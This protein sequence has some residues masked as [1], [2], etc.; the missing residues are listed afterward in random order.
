MDTVEERAKFT[1]RA[2]NIKKWYNNYKSMLKDD[3]EAIDICSPPNV[4]AE[5]AIMAR[6]SH[7]VPFYNEIRH[8]VFS[9]LHDKS[10]KVTLQDGSESL[11]VAIAIN[12]AIEQRKEIYL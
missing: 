4:H 2:F 11:K 12:K 10:P 5:Q 8:F 3:I 6:D 1:A 9:I 7:L